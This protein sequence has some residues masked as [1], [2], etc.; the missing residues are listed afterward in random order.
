MTVGELA[1]YADEMPALHAEWML[2]AAQ[3]AAYPMTMQL[4]PEAAKAWWDGWASAAAGAVT[5]VG[6][7]VTKAADFTLNGVSLTFDKLSQQISRM[8]GGG[9]SE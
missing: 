5:V 8:L 2:D 4:A 1:A 9:V 3:A 7:V 6:E